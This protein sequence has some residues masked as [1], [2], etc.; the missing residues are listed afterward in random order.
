MK[1]GRIV[2]LTA[3]RQAGKKAV[4]VKQN[5]DGN[6]KKNFAHALVVGVERPPRKV[7]RSMSKKK[8]DRK[9]RLKP[10]VKFVNYNHMMPTRFVM[11]EDLDFKNVVNDERMATAETRKTMKADLKA[12]LQQRYLKPEAAG[13]KQAAADFLFKKLRF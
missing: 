4:I 5:D 8:I 2:I 7:K 3:G 13:E 11:K 10:F 6:K 12:M 9:C 1:K